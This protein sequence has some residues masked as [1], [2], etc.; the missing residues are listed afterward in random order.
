MNGL[1]ALWLVS[2]VVIITISAVYL[3]IWA[4]TH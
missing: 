4:V 3:P 2:M 1:S